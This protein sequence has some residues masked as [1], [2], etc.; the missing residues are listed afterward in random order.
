MANINKQ[1]EKIRSSIYGKD[2]RE[3]IA[4]TLES[5]NSQCEQTESFSNDKVEEMNHLKQTLEEAEQTRIMN[6]SERSIHENER[7]SEETE[8]NLRFQA[9]DRETQFQHN[10]IISQQAFLE[11]AIAEWNDQ[12]DRGEFHGSFWLY[13]NGVPNDDIGKM[14]DW[15][16]DRSSKYWCIYHRDHSGWTD[17]GRNLIGNDGSMGGDTVPIG[18]I[19]PCTTNSVPDGWLL[20]DGS[21]IMRRDYPEL[22]DVIGESY[23]AGDGVTTFALPNILNPLAYT[24]STDAIQ[25][26]ESNPELSMIIKA[27]QAIPLVGS[28]QNDLTSNSEKDAPSIKAV[29]GMLKTLYPVGTILEFDREMDMTSI[30]GGTWELFGIGRSTICINT[31]DADFNSGLKTG[32]SKIHTMTLAEMPAHNH[33]ASTGVAKVMGSSI[34]VCKGTYTADSVENKA[35][36]HA[37][38]TPNTVTNHRDATVNSSDIPGGNHYHDVTISVVGLGNAMNIMNPYVVVYRYR[39]IAN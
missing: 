5:M 19:L 7:I 25:F 20:C 37:P 3:S 27:K 4:S 23:G 9:L 32:G 34:R 15:Y 22:F 1:I 2:V 8:R 14:N 38:A 36:N 33:V 24:K 28:V 30:Y 35:N 26:I 21:S 12:K 39:K 17:T 11:N 31:N 10:Q 6:E 29:N 13:G 16:I 18:A